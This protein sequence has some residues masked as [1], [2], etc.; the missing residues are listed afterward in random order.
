MLSMNNYLPILAAAVA[1]VVIA[2]LWYSNIMFGKMWVREGGNCLMDKKDAPMKLALQTL[3]SILL[4]TA[5]MIAINIFHQS[6][7]ASATVSGFSRIF[8]WFL[9]STSQGPTMM[10][11]MKVAGFFWMGFAMPTIASAAVW[12][13]HSLNRFLICAGGELVSL[14][15]MGATL[16]YL[17]NIM[18]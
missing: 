8:S 13:N 12:C 3:C 1:H 18:A 16:A 9:S 5:V 17:S 15:C 4:A 10:N 2:C 14:A 6:Q 11:A 7:V